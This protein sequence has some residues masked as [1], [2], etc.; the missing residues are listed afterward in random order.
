MYEIMGALSLGVLPPSASRDEMIQTL[1]PE[2]SR[3]ARRKWRKLWRKELKKQRKKWKEV[4]RI[5]GNKE[6]DSFMAKHDGKVAIWLEGR[7]I[8]EKKD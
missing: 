4:P 8:F 5:A 7:R 3:K 1:S 2:D 6:L